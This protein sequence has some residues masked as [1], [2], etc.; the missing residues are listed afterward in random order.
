M[1]DLPS[2]YEAL[3]FPA[4]KLSHQ[5][6]SSPE[7]TP[8]VTVILNRPKAANAFSVEMQ[9]SLIHIFN[10]LSTDP[11]VK[12]IIL[13]GSDPAN[14][15]FC[16]GMD[17]SAVSDKPASQPLDAE[18]TVNRDTH[19]DGGGRV[20]LAIFRCNKP[21]IAAM[22][23]S[24]V[25]VGITMT[26]P[27]AIRVTHAKA[28]FGFVF[29]RRGLSLEGCSSFFLPRLIGTSRAV[30]LATTGSVYPATD[31]LL[32]GLFTVVEEPAGVLPKAIEI[33]EDVVKNC[34]A[35]STTV[36]RDMI[37][38]TP[39]SPEEAHLNESKVIFDLFKGKDFIEGVQSFLQKRNPNLEGTMPKD[40]PS[41]WPW[42]KDA[43]AGGKAR[44]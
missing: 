32:E 2:S 16:A 26:L 34:S 21:V 42:W 18:G 39:A 12:C 33:A 31:K 14:K 36:M 9:T 44:L 30:H 10:L 38:R 37:Y 8:I 29:A 22:N 27:C 6:P 25:G 7:V 24:G 17:L 35:V 5:P 19:R 43:L 20:S 11:R 3:Q 1:A 40:A 28:K 13:T 15:I 4:I 41:V 23:G